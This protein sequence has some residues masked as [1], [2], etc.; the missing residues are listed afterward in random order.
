MVHLLKN[1][2]KSETVKLT[3]ELQK[4][5]KEPC[6]PL[7]PIIPVTSFI[8]KVSHLGLSCLQSGRPFRPVTLVTLTFLKI[9]GQERSLCVMFP[10]DC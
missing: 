4:Y 6:F 3:E 2:K 7:A 9:M 8:A 5:H 1:L 10:C